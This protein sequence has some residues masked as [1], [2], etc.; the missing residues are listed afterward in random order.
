MSTHQIWPCH[1][2]QDAGLE[3]FKLCTN[4]KFNI[5]KGHKISSGKVLYFKS[6]HPK[7]SLGVFSAIFDTQQSK[8]DIRLKG[9]TILFIGEG[10]YY[11][12]DLQ[13]IFF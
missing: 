3:I 1:V 10:G 12:W 5:G 7:T 2:T 6:Y 13:T 8:D 4:S 11:F 9:R